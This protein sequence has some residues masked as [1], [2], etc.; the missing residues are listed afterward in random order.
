MP[1]RREDED[2]VFNNV[3]A[4]EVYRGEHLGD[5]LSVMGQL[6]P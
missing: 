3:V 1:T 4:G 2:G 6:L 5:L